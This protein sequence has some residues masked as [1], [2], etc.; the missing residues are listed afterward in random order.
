MK[1][2][3]N[4]GLSFQPLVVM[5]HV[6]CPA[7]HRQAQPGSTRGAVRQAHQQSPGGLGVLVASNGFRKVSTKGHNNF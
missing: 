1:T 2:V 3:V 6:V 7:G 4:V 5:R